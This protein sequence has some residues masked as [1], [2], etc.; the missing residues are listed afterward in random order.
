MMALRIL[1]ALLVLALALA[2]MALHMTVVA[3]QLVVAGHRSMAVVSLIGA[4]AWFALWLRALP[5]IRK[6]RP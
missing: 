5:S 3:P 1:L 2:P 4:V 6:V